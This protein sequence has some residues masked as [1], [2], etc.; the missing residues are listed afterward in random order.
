M[1]SDFLS[2]VAE[3]TLGPGQTEYAWRRGILGRGRC[4]RER[5]ASLE[6]I[7]KTEFVRSCLGTTADYPESG[8][9]GQNFVFGE[10]LSVVDFFFKN[11]GLW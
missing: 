1:G 6:R 3:K 11:V 9:V 5:R 10:F 7:K 4:V 8:V 2:S